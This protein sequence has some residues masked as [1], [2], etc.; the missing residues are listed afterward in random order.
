MSE[1]AWIVH[2]D[3]DALAEAVCGRIERIARQAVAARGQALLAL[4]GGR[5]PIPIFERLR[6]CPLPWERV[7]ILPTDERL[8]TAVHP[9]SNAALLARHSGLAARGWSRSSQTPRPIIAW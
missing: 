5:S 6:E 2:D 3:G 8:V 7:T 9:L 4:P 1:P